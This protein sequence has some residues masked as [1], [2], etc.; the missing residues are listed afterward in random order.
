[1]A[2]DHLPCRPGLRMLALKYRT[3]ESRVWLAVMAFHCSVVE[4]VMASSNKIFFFLLFKFHNSIII[5]NWK[6]T[7]RSLLLFTLFYIREAFAHAWS[8]CCANTWEDSS[9]PPP[10]VKESVPI[11]WF[12]VPS[13]Y[14]CHNWTEYI[15]WIFTRV[16][17]EMGWT[18]MKFSQHLQAISINSRK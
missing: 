17:L 5:L 16:R 15:V 12:L 9:F 11:F 7:Q 14:P 3:R 13:L 2:K 10:E 1:M 6:Q 8:I 4:Q 18:A